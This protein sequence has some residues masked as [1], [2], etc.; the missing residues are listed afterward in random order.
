MKFRRLL[1]ALAA[2]ALLAACSSASDDNGGISNTATAPASVPMQ[3][4]APVNSGPA[5][6][7][8]EEFMT[9]VGDRV[10]FSLDQYNLSPQ[11]Q[12]SLR[13]Q[14]AWLNR[15]ANRSVILEGHADERGTREYNLALGERRASSAR[16]YLVA[17]GI[18]PQRIRVI[19]YGKE[20]PVCGQSTDACWNQNRRAVTVLQ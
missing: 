8:V 16:D 11:A 7:S 15:Y 9:V 10:F 4:A 6:G 2:A 18:A 14:A 20:R 5:P 3:S 13:S 12:A 17:Q 1:P 19:S